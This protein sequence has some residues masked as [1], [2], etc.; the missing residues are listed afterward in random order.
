M[1]S[2]LNCYPLKMECY[3]NGIIYISLMVTM[4]E[5]TV[6]NTKK[7]RKKKIMIKELKCTTTKSLQNTKAARV[8]TK[9][10]VKK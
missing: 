4:K 9:Y 8:E 2:T 5:K 6:V 3:N 7:K 10:I 1:L